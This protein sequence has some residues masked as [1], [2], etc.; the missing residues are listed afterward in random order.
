[1]IWISQSVSKPDFSLVLG[2]PLFQLLR[3]DVVHIDLNAD[4]GTTKYNR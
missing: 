4:T 2:G 1:M 3:R